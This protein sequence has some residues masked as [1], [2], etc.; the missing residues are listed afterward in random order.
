MLWVKKIVKHLVGLEKGSTFAIPNDEEKRRETAGSCK[1][2]RSLKIMNQGSG[3][4]FLENI[5]P[6]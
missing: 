6:E 2:N 5:S 3:D 1:G 4:M